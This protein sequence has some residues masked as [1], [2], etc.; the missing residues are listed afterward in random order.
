MAETGIKMTYTGD[1][2]TPRFTPHVMPSGKRYQYV[3]GATVQADPRDVDVLR[4]LQF[5]EVKTVD[6]QQQHIPESAFETETNRESI[7]REQQ[8]LRDMAEQQDDDPSA[9]DTSIAASLYDRPN[10]DD[11]PRDSERETSE[12]DQSESEPK[13]RGR[14]RKDSD[15]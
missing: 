10:V 13:R 5:E 4:R 7:E 11:Q 3:A 15:A 14:P 1:V 9:D 8:A 12:E 2:S 6:D